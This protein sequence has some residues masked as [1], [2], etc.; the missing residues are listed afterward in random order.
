VPGYIEAE[1]TEEEVKAMEESRIKESEQRAL[2][3]KE[4]FE[5]REKKSI[6]E[7][8]ELKFRRLLAES[9]IISIEAKLQKKRK[10]DSLIDQRESATSYVPLHEAE[11]AI[12]HVEKCIGFEVPNTTGFFITVK[13]YHETFDTLKFKRKDGSDSLIAMPEDF[14]EHLEEKEK[15][16]ACCGL[17]IGMGPDCYKDMDRFSS[18]PWCRI[19]DFVTFMLHNANQTMY[20]GFAVAD[21]PDDKIMRVIQSPKDVSIS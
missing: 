7:S 20:K 8:Q 12:Q 9:D 14:K 15:Y 10:L 5:L 17:V 2:E 21:L 1:R 6:E 18:G 3:I 16:R 11:M 19:G 13:L 4:S